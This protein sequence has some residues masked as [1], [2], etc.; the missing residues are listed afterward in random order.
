MD[1]VLDKDDSLIPFVL[2]Q[3]L[4]TT[5]TG[6]TLS[7]PDL[8][9]NPIVYANEAFEEITGYRREEI[10]GRN[11]RFLQGDDR[12]Q[13]EIDRIR[14]AVRERQ[15]VTVTLR[16]YRRDGTLFH[17]RF[18]VRPL[19]D[20]HGALIYFLG[21]QHD[22]TREVQAEE[23]LRRVQAALDALRAEQARD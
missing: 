9:D 2:A 20:R 10:L 14:D 3:I 19:F 16:N 22:V 1:L 15:A 7:D 23:E 11:C 4:D 18:S 13:P 8:D 6:I 12:E 21:V 5:V 17:N